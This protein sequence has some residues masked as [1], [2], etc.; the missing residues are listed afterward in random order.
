MWLWPPFIK[1]STTKINKLIEDKGRLTTAQIRNSL[2]EVCYSGYMT[3]VNLV[4]VPQ[5]KQLSMVVFLNKN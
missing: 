5:A 3:T 1:R 2:V 4:N